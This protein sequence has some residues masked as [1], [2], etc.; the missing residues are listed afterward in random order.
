MTDAEA[1]RYFMTI[2]EACELVISTSIIAEQRELYLLD[3]GKPVRIIDL[4]MKMIHLSDLRLEE[5]ISIVYTG[6]RPGERLHETLVASDEELTPTANIKI[7][8]VTQIDDLPTPSMVIQWINT[9]EHSLLYENV[10]QQRERLFR[11]IRE[12][13]LLVIS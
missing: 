3:M 5:D 8:R 9:L 13:K 7:L 1:T 10:A 2:P 6:L 12:Q 4:A 11:I